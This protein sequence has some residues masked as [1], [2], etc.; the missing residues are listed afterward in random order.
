MRTLREL[1]RI[2]NAGALAFAREKIEVLA[3]DN[4]VQYE[5]REEAQKLLEKLQGR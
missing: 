1:L 4:T 3:K 5:T 2:Q